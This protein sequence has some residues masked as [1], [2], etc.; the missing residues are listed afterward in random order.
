[1]KRVGGSYRQA[2][3]GDRRGSAAGSEAFGRKSARVAN[4][5]SI[6]PSGDQAGG[7]GAVRGFAGGDGT[8][9]TPAIAAYLR[10][11]YLL[12]DEGRPVATQ[13][14]A[15]ALGVS[16]PSVT[17]MVKRLH[18]LGLLHHVRYQGVA[19]TVSGERIALRAT[20]CHRLLELY[21][22]EALGYRWDEVDVEAERLSYDLSE[23]L[24][25]RLDAALGY[26]TLDPHGHPIPSREGAL[27]PV[28]GRRLLDLEPGAVAV[29]CRVSDRNRAQLRYL[30]ELGLSPG[31]TVAVVELLP[32]DG[33][34]R[35]RVG[36]AE[37][38]ISRRLAVS[39]S[40]SVKGRCTDDA[41]T[42]ERAARGHQNPESGK[43]QRG[44]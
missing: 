12:Q 39:V 26:P 17:N 15:R 20:R 19:L 8:R 25:A 31:V 37:R 16:S 7:R 34:V 28:A 13:R 10:T 18:E 5:E 35:I 22:V 30:A 1:M 6:R 14:I 33:P 9:V 41:A 23:E 42:D 21:L 43:G 2:D 29:I 11:V 24:V 36:V 3:A 44:D 4:P 38:V 32:F 40:V 27:V